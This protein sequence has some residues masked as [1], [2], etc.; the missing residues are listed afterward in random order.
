M[1]DVGRLVEFGAPAALLDAGGH[2]ARLVEQTGTVMAK[3]LRTAAI[4]A[5]PSC[6]LRWSSVM[7]QTAWT[8]IVSLYHPSYG[9]FLH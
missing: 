6:G 9:A 3:Y 2:L 5:L 4:A 8:E 7:E 1:L